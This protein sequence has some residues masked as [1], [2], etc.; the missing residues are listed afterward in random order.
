LESVSAARILSGFADAATII[1]SNET[2]A[3][4]Q[5]LPLTRGRL[6]GGVSLSF[7]FQS[8]RAAHPS[9]EL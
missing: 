7:Y 6:G 9:H 1:E 3:G 2:G 8:R 4:V 5:F